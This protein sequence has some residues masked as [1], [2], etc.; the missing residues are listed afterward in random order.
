MVFSAPHLDTRLDRRSLRQCRVKAGCT[1]SAWSS[2]D[3][4]PLSGACG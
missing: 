1:F 2:M 3:S 4:R